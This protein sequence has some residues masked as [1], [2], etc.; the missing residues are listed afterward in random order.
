MQKPPVHRNISVVI[1]TSHAPHPNEVYIKDKFKIRPNRAM[2][3]LKS[4]FG[5][6]EAGLKAGGITSVLLG[7]IGGYFFGGGAIGGAIGLASGLALAPVLNEVFFKIGRQYGLITPP[8][9]N[10]TITPN[11][12]VAD[13]AAPVQQ[14]GGKMSETTVAAPILENM[15]PPPPQSIAENIERRED[16]WKRLIEKRGTEAEYHA[17]K[18]E[19]KK[20]ETKVDTFIATIDEYHK[21]RE[22]YQKKDGKRDQ[23]IT[24][25][26]TALLRPGVTN[27]LTDGEIN[28]FVPQL[29]AMPPA[30]QEQAAK[31]MAEALPA[32]LPLGGLFDPYNL[33]DAARLDFTRGSATAPDPAK[34]EEW[35]KKSTLERLNYTLDKVDDL[36]YRD[37]YKRPINWEL[38]GGSAEEGKRIHDLPAAELVKYVQEQK[39]AT[40]ASNLRTPNATT[41]ERDVQLD[42]LLGFAKGRYIHDSL[43]KLVKEKLGGT[44]Q[45]YTDFRNADLVPATA[46]ANE[47]ATARLAVFNETGVAIMEKGQ[48]QAAKAPSGK[49]A[50]FL[51]YKDIT[52][53]AGSQEVTLVLQ[54]DG[55]G[56]TFVTHKVVGGINKEP[57]DWN[58][59]KLKGAGVRVRPETFVNLSPET[60][61]TIGQSFRE[62]LNAITT[63]PKEIAMESGAKM[64]D[65]TRQFQETQP[66]PDLKFAAADAPATPS[67]STQPNAKALKNKD[68][69]EMT[70]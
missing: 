60:G 55:S 11:V 38:I 25:V 28:R 2:E 66:V 64:Q 5:S 30:M 6:Q 36:R 32:K 46:Q 53:P 17:A 68:K 8:P 24:A 26:K 61:K 1:Q 47:F 48:L 22:D 27:S 16:L 9:R 58:K 52:A 31:L 70:V 7:T 23:L 45:I 10:T 63:A 18:E 50:Q 43:Q 44:M 67:L 65:L 12:P 34:E 42:R 15:A 19:T 51:T 62:M 3:F 29:P 37:E 13:V 54:N 56:Q 49:D 59:A 14:P 69:A 20:L 21:V 4:I 33:A 35:A 39:S 40:A 57:V 41:T